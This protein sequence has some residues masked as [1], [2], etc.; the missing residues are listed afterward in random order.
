LLA[1][2]GAVLA[3]RALP[4][5]ILTVAAGEFP[6]V[7]DASFGDWMPQSRLC[8]ISGMAGSQQGW[9]EAPYCACPAG[10]ADVAARLAW[11]EPGRIAI[12]PGLS[13]LS[14]GVPDVMRGEETQ[15]FGA[16]G[17]LGLDDARLVLP[18]THSKWVNVQAGRITDFSTW[19]TGEFYA[20]L[21]Q[22]SILARTLPAVEPPLDKQAFEQ[23]V[24][25]ALKGAG[26]LHTAFS[27]RTLSLFKKLSPDALPSYLSGLVIGEELKSQPLQRGDSVV[28]MGAEALTARYEQALAQLGVSVKAVGNHATWTGLQAIAGTLASSSG[29]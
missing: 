21:R 11:I 4:R 22:H 24:A 3:E 28:V 17:L 25:Q 16:L 1:P 19:M 9:L 10:F 2:D 6:A 26:L 15:V 27:T 12:V 23:G 13:T 20:L 18:G 29:S 8:L 7:F 5:G 14:D